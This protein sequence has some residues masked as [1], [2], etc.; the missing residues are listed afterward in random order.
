VLY[1]QRPEDML[2]KQLLLMTGGSEA[3]GAPSTAAVAGD[4][5]TQTPTIAAGDLAGNWSATG[6]NETSFALQLGSKGDFTWTFT[7]NGKA[8]TVKGVY[9]LDGNVLAME[10]E[11]GGVM[12]A[13]V[14]P[15]KGKQFEFKMLGAPPGDQ[16]LRFEQKG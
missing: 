11:T 12:L 8:E 3:I 5:A 7:H 9:A 13:E 14:T 1:K 4:Q 10:P 15:P 16:G 6:Q 2:V